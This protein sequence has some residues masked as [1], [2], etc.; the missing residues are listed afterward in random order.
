[1]ARRPAARILAERHQGLPLEV[2][3]ELLAGAPVLPGLAKVAKRRRLRG[4]H[5]APPARLAWRQSAH[6]PCITIAGPTASTLE[7]MGL[8][9]LPQW[10]KAVRQA[11]RKSAVTGDTGDGPPDEPAAPLLVHTHRRRLGTSGSPALLSAC[12]PSGLA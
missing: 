3:R 11:I 12:E 4:G 9:T 7:W 6:S 2:T 10:F 5:S 8:A 1:M